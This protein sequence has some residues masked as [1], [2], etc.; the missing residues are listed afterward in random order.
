MRRSPGALSRRQQKQLPHLEVLVANG[1]ARVPP[2]GGRLG[3]RVPVPSRTGWPHTV[4]SCYTLP[5]RGR[6]AG[7]VHAGS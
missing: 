2:G 4:A 7:R 3:T 1:T 6:G 5:G